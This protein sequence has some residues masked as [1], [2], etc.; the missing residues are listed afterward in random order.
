MKKKYNKI[1]ASYDA[2][3]EKVKRINTKKGQVNLAKLAEV[4]TT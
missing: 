4:D 1:R 2:S 3:V